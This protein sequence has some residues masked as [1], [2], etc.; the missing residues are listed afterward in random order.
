MKY[1]AN[2]NGNIPTHVHCIS[3]FDVLKSDHNQYVALFKSNFKIAKWAV[4]SSGHALQSVI[5]V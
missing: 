4:T 3:V 2:V 5:K 1:S